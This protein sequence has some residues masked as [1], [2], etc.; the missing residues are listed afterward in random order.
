MTGLESALQRLNLYLCSYISR[1]ALFAMHVV[2]LTCWLWVRSL[3]QV[4][5]PETLKILAT[6]IAGETW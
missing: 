1:L 6:E 5:S 4:V 3:Q 2:S